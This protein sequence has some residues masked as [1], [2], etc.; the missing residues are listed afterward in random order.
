MCFFLIG[1]GI[2]FIF[3]FLGH[4]KYIIE[5]QKGRFHEHASPPFG[6]QIV[7]VCIVLI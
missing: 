2:I 6:I 4:S 5:A 1:L 7:L 3:I